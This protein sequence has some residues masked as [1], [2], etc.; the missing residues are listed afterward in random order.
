MS[1]ISP[2]RLP[3]RSTMTRPSQPRTVSTLGVDTVPPPSLLPTGGHNVTS[4]EPLSGEGTWLSARD[5]SLELTLDT[6]LPHHRVATSHRSAAAPRREA[7]QEQRRHDQPEQPTD[8]QNDPDRV[9]IE[10]R[11][12][13][14]LHREGEDRA[15]HEQEQA[16]A[17]AHLHA[18]LMLRSGLPS[19]DCYNSEGT[20][21]SRWSLQLM[22]VH[23]S[24]A[25]RPGVQRSF[26][27]KAE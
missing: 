23:S 5:P 1:V 12:G 20:P 24:T 11:A 17:N 14:D 25:V 27:R 18:S 26:G 21:P 8:H 4:P 10:P 13:V 7:T 2:S 9:E 16:K 19:A 22:A 6:A 15:D 3:S